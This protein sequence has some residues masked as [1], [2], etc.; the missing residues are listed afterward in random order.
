M[1]L[2]ASM[3]GWAVST[4]RPG[5]TVGQFGTFSLPEVDLAPQLTR[6]HVEQVVHQPDEVR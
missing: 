6:A 3:T 2:A 4:A 5:P 1:A